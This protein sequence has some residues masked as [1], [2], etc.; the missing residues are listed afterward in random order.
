MGLEVHL[1]VPHLRRKLGSEFRLCNASGLPGFEKTFKSIAGKSALR[2]VEE[3]SLGLAHCSELGTVPNAARSEIPDEVRSDVR[4]ER[5]LDRRIE[6]FR[7][8]FKVCSCARNVD[9]TEVGKLTEERLVL[10]EMSNKSRERFEPRIDIGK[11]DHRGEAGTGR[12][13]K[14]WELVHEIAQGRLAGGSTHVQLHRKAGLFDAQLVAEI[15]DLFRFR[16]EVLIPLVGEDEIE[17]EKPGPDRFQSM[18]AAVAEVLMTKLG[19]KLTRIQMI[20]APVVPVFAHGGMPL[21]DELLGQRMCSIATL[22]IDKG[23]E[24]T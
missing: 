1:P 24:L 4:F 7:S 3:K 13:E 15:G 19:V 14:Q 17:T 16:F 9:E 23:Q 6:E 2:F 22:G 20:N 8:L 18:T 21:G 10:P 11:R 12:T 5:N